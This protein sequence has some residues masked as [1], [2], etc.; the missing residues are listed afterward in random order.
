MS[1]RTELRICEV[2]GR[3]FVLGKNGISIIVQL[4]SEWKRVA[5]C[6]E[7]GGVQR[8]A[9][10][11]GHVYNIDFKKVTKMLNEKEAIEKN[12]VA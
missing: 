7:C 8:S 11:H 10:R 9:N 6:D 3:S 5:V 1:A 4:E 12:Q 2:C